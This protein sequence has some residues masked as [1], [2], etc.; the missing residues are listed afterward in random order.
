MNKATQNQKRAR[1]IY[2]A[3]FAVL[4]AVEIIIGLYVH[5]QFV[6]PYIGDM[7]VVVLLWALVRMII[8]FRA[9]WL[10]GAIYVFAVL[11]ELSQMIPLVDFLEIENRLIRVLMGTSFAVGDLFAY[12]AGCIVT[13]IV[14]IAVF[15][16][17]KQN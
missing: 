16:H 7:L 9:V 13:A 14:D 1:L 2:A 3:V 17:R 15:R 4:F 12:A 11:V 6:R 10:S 8:P 5:D